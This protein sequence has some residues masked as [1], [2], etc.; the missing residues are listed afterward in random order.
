MSEINTQIFTAAVIGWPNGDTLKY[1]AEPDPKQS[2][3]TFK[4]RADKTSS[5]FEI[6]V[7]I[8]LKLTEKKTPKLS[9]L[10]LSIPLSTIET[11]TSQVLATVPQPVRGKPSSQVLGL[12]FKLNENVTVLIPLDTKEQPAQGK[13]QSG[14]VLDNVREISQIRSF[15]VYIDHTA[16]HEAKLNSI[17]N[18][19]N[20][21]CYR[22]TRKRQVDLQ[23]LYQGQSAQIAHLTPQL[24]ELPAYDDVPSSSLHITT[25]RRKRPR[26]ELNDHESE[27]S[28]SGAETLKA[29]SQKMAAFE[30]AA[31]EDQTVEERMEAAQKEIEALQQRIKTTEQEIEAL[32]QQNDKVDFE[33]YDEKL[34]EVQQEVNELGEKYSGINESMVTQENLRDFGED[35]IQDIGNKILGK[36]H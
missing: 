3:L 27:I 31:S 9:S 28:T 24:D 20:E 2:T 25:Q 30:M 19:I 7:P 17:R 8:Y 36:D 35:L 29:L 16:S 1:L 22:F 32:Q 13:T 15:S 34:W 4:T 33:G 26:R 23:S 12:Y 6:W 14:V 5:V 10:I 21:G 18:A 11:L